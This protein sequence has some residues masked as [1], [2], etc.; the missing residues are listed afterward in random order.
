MTRDEVQ[1]YDVFGDIYGDTQAEAV[2]DGEWVRYE[3]HA[4]ALAAMKAERD[5]LA[6][7]LAAL[8]EPS[9]AAMRAGNRHMLAMYRGEKNGRKYKLP[10]WGVISDIL[11]AAVEAAEQEAARE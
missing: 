11:P 10:L 8:R 3:D 6:C 5:M 1:R 2:P 4:K 9:E 7:I